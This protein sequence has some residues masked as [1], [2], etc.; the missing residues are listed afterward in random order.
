M[1]MW[2][3]LKEW[4]IKL[5]ENGRILSV[6]LGQRLNIWNLLNNTW[7]ILVLKRPKGPVGHPRK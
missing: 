1:R 3:V 4:L 2:K 7:M 5:A 6:T